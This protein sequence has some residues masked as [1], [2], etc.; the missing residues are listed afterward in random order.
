[1]QTHRLIPPSGSNK[2]RVAGPN[3]SLHVAPQVTP[4]S[5]RIVKQLIF[6]STVSNTNVLTVR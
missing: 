2:E 1:M 3:L 5:S 4:R 6:C